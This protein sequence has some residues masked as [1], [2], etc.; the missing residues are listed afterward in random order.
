MTE[1]PK[2][3][4][5]IDLQLYLAG[6][7]PKHKAVLLWF[8]LLISKNLKEKMKRIQRDNYEFINREYPKLKKKLNFPALES[9]SDQESASNPEHLQ[10]D[11]PL[12]TETDNGFRFRLPITAAPWKLAAGLAFVLFLSVGIY[13]PYQM[14]KNATESALFTAKGRSLGI[15]LYAKGKTVRRIE[16]FSVELPPSDTLQVMPVDWK[17]SI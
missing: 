2:T 15:H 7:L 1:K 9:A 3:L 14:S 4:T 17:N 16:N 10:K 6:A 13:M 11:I 5:D 8:A 12:S